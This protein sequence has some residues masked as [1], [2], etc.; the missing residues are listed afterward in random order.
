MDEETVLRIDWA[1]APARKPGE[2]TH[3]YAGIGYVGMTTIPQAG[4][5]IVAA[6]RVCHGIPLSVLEAAPKGHAKEWFDVWNALPLEA[7]EH[8]GGPEAW[9]REAAEAL[10][11]RSPEGKQ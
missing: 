1:L 5:L 6:K 4:Q 11:A 2:L 10:R 8:P 7:H 3:I 9:I